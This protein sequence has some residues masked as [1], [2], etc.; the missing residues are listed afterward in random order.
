MDGSEV[1]QESAVTFVMILKSRSKKELS[2]F[3]QKIHTPSQ[4]A[5][6]GRRFGLFSRYRLSKIHFPLRF[7]GVG[8]VNWRIPFPHDW[9]YAVRAA[10]Y[11]RTRFWRQRSGLSKTE[12]QICSQQ[13]QLNRFSVLTEVL[14]LAGPYR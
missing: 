7:A 12:R 6:Y 2:N 14:Q 3:P 4:F 1:R 11:P 9:Q 13:S 5:L 10:L 8:F